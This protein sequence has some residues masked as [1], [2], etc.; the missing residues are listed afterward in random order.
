MNIVVWSLMTQLSKHNIVL[1]ST[2]CLI[3]R[4]YE[5]VHPTHI[6]K[7]LKK[8]IQF[9]INLESKYLHLNFWPPFVFN[10]FD[11]VKMGSHFLIYLTIEGELIGDEMRITL[12]MMSCHT[13]YQ[14]SNSA[15]I[16]I[17][18]ESY[19]HFSHING[20]DYNDALSHV[21]TRNVFIR[22]HIEEADLKHISV[23]GA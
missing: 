23:H 13:R 2:L 19:E 22:G 9:F 1:V 17:H 15:K 16:T 10:L 14:T 18:D 8:N 6:S 4:L 5:H 21:Q 20:N 11:S 12:S 7:I 3:D